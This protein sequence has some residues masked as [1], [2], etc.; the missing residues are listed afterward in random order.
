MSTPVKLTALPNDH[1][2]SSRQTVGELHHAEGEIIEL[3][4]ANY[5]IRTAGHNALLPLNLP[6]DFQQ[7]GLKIFF[8]GSM[9]EIGLNEFMAGQPIV[10]SEIVRK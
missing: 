3:G 10:L 8:S 9:K 7:E 4:P 6:D 1:P 5:G 2:M